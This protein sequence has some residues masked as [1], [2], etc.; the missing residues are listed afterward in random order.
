[1][2]LLGI[3]IGTTGCKAA[4]FSGDGDLIAIAYR[5]Y[6]RMSLPDGYAELNSKLVLNDIW[7]CISEVAAQTQ[8]DP[9]EALSVSSFGEAMVPVTAER[10][11]IGNCI[12][13]SDI[14]GQQYISNLLEEIN[15]EE[16]YKI[17]TNI[18]GV[19]YSLPKILWVKENQPEIY[20]SAYKFLLWADLVIYMLGGDPVANYSLA[21]RTMFFDIHNQSWSK[22]ILSLTNIDL[23]KFPVLVPSGTLA[24]VIDRNI[25][26]KLNLPKI[27]KLIVGGHDQCCNA[28]GSGVYEEGKTVC[29]MGTFECF[30]PVYECIPRSTNAF[31]K[32]GLNIEN[33]VVPDRYVSFL[34]N[35]SGSLVK[36]YRDTFATADKRLL[37]KGED[38]YMLLISEIPM[39]PTNLFVLPHFEITGPPKFIA[40]HCGVIFGLK[41]NTKRGEILKSIMECTTLYFVESLNKLKKLELK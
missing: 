10:E 23:E 16:F 22:K 4:S 34:Y 30:T 6:A 31:L 14:R 32:Y 40:D 38:I 20:R 8:T 33:H 11:I 27:T 29:G 15:Q 5:E 21:N 17:N 18:I 24:G 19:N 25:A 37:R 13:S 35:Q 36:W 12:L 9:I 7:D 26:E 39:E 41:T 28:L 3:D 2:S 1:M